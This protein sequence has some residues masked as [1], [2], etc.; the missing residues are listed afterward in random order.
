MRVGLS[1]QLNLLNIIT[2]EDPNYNW[3]KVDMKD[4]IT[5][6]NVLVIPGISK[7]SEYKQWDT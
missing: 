7:N 4:E 2:D 3:L 5:Q 1:N 6:P